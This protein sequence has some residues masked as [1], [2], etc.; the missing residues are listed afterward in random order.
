MVKFYV[1][2]KKPNSRFI[3]KGSRI[4][5]GDEYKSIIKYTRDSN[6][7][8]GIIM[9]GKLWKYLRYICFPFANFR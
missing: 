2:K 9:N 8:K 6:D 5:G 3:S 1:I 4:G 7:I